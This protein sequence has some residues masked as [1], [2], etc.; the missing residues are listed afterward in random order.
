MKPLDL[1]LISKAR[2]TAGYLLLVVALALIATAS[3]VFIAW[4]LSSFIVELFINQRELSEIEKF[5]WFALIGAGVRAAVYFSQD[6]AGF[7]A[8]GKVKLKLRLQ[9]LNA[10]E[11]G[12]SEL[13]AKYGSAELSQL[14]GPSLDALDVYFSKYLPQ[15]VFT[16]LVTPALTV[17]IWL[18]DPPSGW[19]IV[20]TLPL[21]PIFLV[22]IGMVTRD[23]QNEQLESLER[24]NGHFLEIVKGLLTLKVFGRIER[25][26]EILTEVSEDYRRRTMGVL[27]LSFLSGFA[28]ELAASLSVALIAV[29]IG[30]RLVEGQLSLFTGLFILIIAPEVYLPLRNVGVQFHAA[31]QGV[32]V[33]SRVLDLCEDKQASSHKSV[34]FEIQP[35]LTVII[36]PSGA[37]KSTLLRGLQ[38]ESSCWM[39]QGDSLLPGTVEHNVVGFQE[40][41]PDQL[42]KALNLAQL[43][44]VDTELLVAEKD[45]LSGGQRQRL[46]LA[47]ALY[48]LN[49]AGLDTL[50][51]DEP[52]SQLDFDTEASIIASFR[53]L[54]DAGVSIVCVSHSQRLIDVADRVVKIDS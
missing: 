52:T 13:V 11:D 47:R 25:Q 44:D 45:G 29:S 53:E 54:T 32:S 43:A 1:R 30:L 51:L 8:A 41:D 48:R 35:G 21:I 50:L 26:R 22:L 10:I 15:L 49:V 46:A 39:P 19:A 3:T 16:I 18:L 12:G 31:A 33:S 28:L 38:N 4:S 37:G 2:A 14:L 7:W 23:R 34:D 36:G 5:L 6:Y 27:R 17:L 40:S 9:A 20:L 24:L 42:R